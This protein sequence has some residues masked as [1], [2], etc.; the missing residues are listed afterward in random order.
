M[1][2]RTGDIVEMTGDMREHLEAENEMQHFAPVEDGD[3]AKMKKMN[4]PR[5]K[6]FMRNKPCPCGSGKKFKKCCWS[7]YA[8]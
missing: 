2:C 5:R 7:K 6:N 4:K 3:V 8:D 1:D